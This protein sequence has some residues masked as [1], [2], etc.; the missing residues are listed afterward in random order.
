MIRHRSYAVPLTAVLLALATGI[1]LGAGPLTDT[2][3]S[4]SP[5][6]RVLTLMPIFQIVPLPALLVL[7]FWFVLQFF[8]GWMSLASSLTGGIAW[9]AHIAGFAFGLFTVKLFEPR[10]REASHAWVE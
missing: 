7:G 5:G 6:T 1:A 8:S 4:A 9:W 10:R 3:S 2:G